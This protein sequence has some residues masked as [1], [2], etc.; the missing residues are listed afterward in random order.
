MSV[1]IEERLAH[2][3]RMAEE[4]SDVVALQ[5]AEIATLKQRVEVLVGRE[6]EREAAGGGGIIL[7]DERPP[8]Y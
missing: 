7:G 3:E 1:D 8:H 2:L 6:A 4:I 5:N